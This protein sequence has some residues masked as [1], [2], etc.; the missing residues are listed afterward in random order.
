MGARVLGDTYAPH[1][2]QRGSE[3]TTLPDEQIHIA[4][5][6]GILVRAH[7]AKQFIFRELRVRRRT[8]HGVRLA[9]LAASSATCLRAS[10]PS[11]TALS[12]S[13]SARVMSAVMPR[14]SNAG[15]RV[16]S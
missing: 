10:M 6:V 14:G 15:L 8:A 3:V 11:Y 9:S 13:I 2:L 12:E 5:Y 16:P 4:L 7:V 1:I